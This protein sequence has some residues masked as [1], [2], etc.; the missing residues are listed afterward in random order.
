MKGKA[1]YQAIEEARRE[2]RP[3]ASRGKAW[4]ITLEEAYMLQR[5]RA[6]GRVLKGYKLGLLSPAKQQ[7]MGIDQPIYG[8]I[9]SEMLLEGPVELSDFVQPRV[10][11]EVAVVLRHGLEASA[12][13]GEIA[14]AIGGYM[15]G[16]DV[17]DSVWEGY[18]FSIEEVVADNASGGG[19]L[20]GQRL[21]PSFP[22]VTLRLYLDG[23]LLGEGSTRVLGN[24]VERL[25]WLL[26]Q[27]GR[28]SGGSVVFLGSVTA[29]R[30]ARAGTLRLE[31]GNE[32][33]ITRLT[34]EC[35]S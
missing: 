30:P 31:G 21:W 13:P 33:L 17:L 6:G 11:P 25:G 27:V 20:L 35:I 28:L 24:P 10:E 7:Q 29:A 8:H 9:F 26:K 2:K 18:R 1:L 12:L 4:G 19:F 23:E 3:I 14:S 15:L 34:G 16:V 22:E 5:R 32:V